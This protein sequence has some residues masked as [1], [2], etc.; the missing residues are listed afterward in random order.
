[1]Q[2]NPEKCQ[3]RKVNGEKI[4]REIAK[5]RMEQR[6]PQMDIDIIKKTLH[7]QIENSMALL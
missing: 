3:S 1:M 7:I 2:S 6:M 4:R 5:E